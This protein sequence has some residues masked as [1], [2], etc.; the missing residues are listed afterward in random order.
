[1]N[2]PFPPLQDSELTELKETID[3]LKVKNTEAQEIIQGALSNPDITTKGTRYVSDAQYRVNMCKYNNGKFQ[4]VATQCAMCTLFS[5]YLEMLNNCQ[6]LSESIPILAS[7]MS[8]T[9]MS[10][11]KELDAK[12]KK[13]KSW[14]RTP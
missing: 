2:T 4:K 11:L 14:V 8:H 10:S 5:W 9:S 3:I 7:D 12:K 6:E 13:K 1:M